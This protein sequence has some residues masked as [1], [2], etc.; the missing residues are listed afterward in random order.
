MEQVKDP[1]YTTILVEGMSCNH[2]KLTVE[3]NLLAIE[4]VKE[5]E[6]DLPS[7]QVKI[8][9]NGIDGQKIANRINELG[10]SYKGIVQ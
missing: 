1:F 3:K 5:V 2:C 10:Y 6:V 4:G 9:G 7:G 8:G